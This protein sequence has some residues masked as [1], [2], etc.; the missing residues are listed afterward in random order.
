MGTISTAT[1]FIE[2]NEQLPKPA[3]CS[4]NRKQHDQYNHNTLPVTERTD[5]VQYIVIEKIKT[6]GYKA[7]GRK[8]TEN[9]DFP[10]GIYQNQ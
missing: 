8:D 2:H 10:E 1:V 4:G 9:G 7:Y 5:E 3:E 6:K